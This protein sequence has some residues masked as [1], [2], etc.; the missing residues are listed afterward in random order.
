MHQLQRPSDSAV[1]G[2]SAGTPATK[3]NGM[4][5]NVAVHGTAPQTDMHVPSQATTSATV[6]P[7]VMTQANGNTYAEL[8]PVDLTGLHQ[9][10]QPAQGPKLSGSRSKEVQ[11]AACDLI[12]FV[13]E[14]KE[15]VQILIRTKFV[16]YNNMPM[17]ATMFDYIAL[18]KKY[19]TPFHKMFK[20]MGMTYTA[21]VKDVKAFILKNFCEQL[22][23]G[24]GIRDLQI[25]AVCDTVTNV[26][27][28]K[29]CF[30]K[31]FV[32]LYC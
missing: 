10:Q 15:L 29:M 14:Q 24:K 2:P 6:P 19:S 9:V 21:Q 31:D 25:Q 20:A 27:M 17:P 28:N 11:S 18:R 8:Q 1:N 5:P 4:Q 16:A 26:Y 32:Q 12:T 7:P 3:T 30:P 13:S 22:Q 23:A